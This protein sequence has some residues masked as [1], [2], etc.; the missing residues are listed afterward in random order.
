M[1]A[2]FKDSFVEC[3]ALRCIQVGL[4]CVQKFTQDRPTMSLVI[5]MLEN[6]GT[7]LPQP[8]QPGFFTERSSNDDASTSTNEESGSQ[9]VVTMTKLDGR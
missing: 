2:S 3:Q 5:F 8:K 6:E 4:L 7:T 1:D 9:N